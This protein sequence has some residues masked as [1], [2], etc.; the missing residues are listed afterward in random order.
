MPLDA[1]TIDR[2]NAVARERREL[3]AKIG[4]RA[5]LLDRVHH[6]PFY[7]FVDIPLPDG[8]AVAMLACNDDY[9]ALRQFWGDPIEPTS[10]AVW[11][12][13]VEAAPPAILDIGAYTGL[14][15]LLAA[16]ISPKSK[17]HAFEPVPRIQARALQNRNV[18]QLGNFSVHRLAAGVEAGRASF[19][20]HAGDGVLPTGSSL[21]PGDRDAVEV[22]EVEVQSIDAFTTARNLPRVGLVKI[23]AERAEI[24]VLRGMRSLLERWRPDIL[25][26]V[27]GMEELRAVQ[28]EL[29]GTS[30]RLFHIDESRPCLL[31]GE[32]P[33]FSRGQNFLVTA[34]SSVALAEMLTDV[35]VLEG[36]R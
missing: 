20:L 16:S 34:R 12:R 32:A 36:G 30:Y 19:H 27:L 26:E 5:S 28:S 4:R 18:N 1:G 11:C 29:A 22:I 9:V 2:L 6:Y 7:G 17:V 3:D 35:V 24:A 14:Y 23:D 21:E 8:R 13:L 31:A 25:L 33:D 15:G 10:V